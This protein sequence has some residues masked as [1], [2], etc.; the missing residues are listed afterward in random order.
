[1]FLCFFFV[2]CLQI[3][4]LLILTVIPWP[5]PSVFKI[6]CPRD[7]ASIVRKIVQKVKVWVDCSLLILI[8]LIIIIIVINFG[9]EESFVFD[10]LQR[11]IPI[12]KKYHVE[13]PLECPFH[14]SRDI[15]Y[16]QESAKH[17][18]RSSQ[19]TCGLCGKSFYTEKHLDLHFDNRHRSFVNTVIV[20]NWNKI[21]NR[22]VKETNLII[23]NWNKNLLFLQN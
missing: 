5:G 17:Q 11:W 18:H 9:E 10:W 23:F 12:L 22:T 16:P 1:M 19:W 15:F 6:S 4:V 8:F 21:Q 20:F 2:F 14:A 3:L 13:L 7:R